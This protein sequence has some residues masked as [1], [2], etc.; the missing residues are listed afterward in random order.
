MATVSGQPIYE[1]DLNDR[2]EKDKAQQMS[3]PLIASIL[4][5]G[6]ITATRVLDVLKQDALDKLINMEVIQQQAR[7][8]NLYP[9]AK[10]Q[11]DLITQ[12]K[13]TDVQPGQSFADS[14]KAHGLTEGQYTRNVITSAVYRVMASKYMPATG[15]ASDRQNAFITWI[16][17]TRESYSVK[18]LIQFSTS[19]ENKPCSSGLP[20]DIDLTGGT[21]PPPAQA[22]SAVPSVQPTVAPMVPRTTP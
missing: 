9:D 4:A 1:Q 8:E 20:S 12:A 13:A 2:Y 11:A 6:G 18:V 5:E 17:K 10:T 22:P 14:L 3:E 7:K 16:C 19:N 21:A 15:S